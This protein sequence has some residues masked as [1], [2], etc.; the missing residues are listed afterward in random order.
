M[1][2]DWKLNNELRGMTFLI[3]TYIF[4]GMTFLILT[5][6]FVMA[7]KKR[8]FWDEKRG[9]DFRFQ[10]FVKIAKFFFGFFIVV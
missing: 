1:P 5:Y 8:N 2:I 3:L 7:A 10:I 9:S 6:I 4:L